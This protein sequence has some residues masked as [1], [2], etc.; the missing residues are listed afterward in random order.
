LLKPLA[1]IL[2]LAGLVA[3]AGCAFP[4][5]SCCSRGDD[6]AS[7]TEVGC[8]PCVPAFSSDGRLRRDLETGAPVYVA[9]ARSLAARAPR[10]EADGCVSRDPESGAPLYE[11]VASG[12]VVRVFVALP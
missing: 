10:F 5:P 12:E 3:A 7:D 9:A 4:A 11:E 1:S 2:A 6:A 8:V